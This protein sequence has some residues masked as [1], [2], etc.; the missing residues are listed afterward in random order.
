MDARE[1]SEYSQLIID[2]ERIS[3]SSSSMNATALSRAALT[4]L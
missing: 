4:E 2:A 1:G 3:F